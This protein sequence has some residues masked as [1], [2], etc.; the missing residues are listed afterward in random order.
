MTPLFA[1]ADLGSLSANSIKSLLVWTV[2]WAVG[3]SFVISTI[4]SGLQYFLSRRQLVST[5]SRTIDNQPIKVQSVEKIVSEKECIER[6]K[7]AIDAV[8][9]VKQQLVK[10]EDA[11]QKDSEQASKD[12]KTI[13]AHI[14]DVRRELSEKIDDMPDRVIATLRNT[15]AI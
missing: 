12:R 14:D 8:E 15:G 1:Q 4:F 2:A 13:Y 10:L 6:H 3:G 11:R 7:S 9:G 5:Q